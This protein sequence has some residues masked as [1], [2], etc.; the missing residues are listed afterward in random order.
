MASTFSI[1]AIT[2]AWLPRRV[3][4]RRSWT[5]SRSER[6]KL[7]AT[8]SAPISTATSRSARSF[9]VRAAAYARE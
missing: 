5:M 4:S 6:T 2:R 9:S 8:R 3:S 7:S 1:F